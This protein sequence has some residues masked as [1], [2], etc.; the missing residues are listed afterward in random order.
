[1]C[2]AGY[3]AGEGEFNFEYFVGSELPDVCDG[4]DRGAKGGIFI[5]LRKGGGAG[6]PAVPAGFRL[7]GKEAQR[8]EGVIRRTW[9]GVYLIRVVGTQLGSDLRT[10]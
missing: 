7:C 6:L 2:H 4:V 8:T 1:M 9:I 10:E 5:E 3:T